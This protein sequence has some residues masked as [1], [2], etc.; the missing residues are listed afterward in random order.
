[1]KMKQGRQLI[2]LFIM[3][4]AASIILF[5]SQPNAVKIFC[6]AVYAFVILSVCFVLMLENRSP[7]KTL[8]WIY[9]LLLFPIAGY[10]F[11]IFSGQLEVNGYLFYKKREEDE[12]YI[13][14]QL[15]N[16]PSEYPDE[17]E[18]TP[19][20]ISAFIQRQ[21]GF[22]VSFHTTTTI[23]KNGQETFSQIK[24]SLLQAKNYI[25][26]EYYTFRPD[27]IGGEIIDILVAKAKEGIEVKLL[28]D[29]VGSL[30]MSAQAIRKMERA[31]IETGC[32]LPV[33]YGFFNQKLNFRNHRKIIV[34]DG[35]TGFA[36]GLNIGDEY[37][38]GGSAFPFWRDTHV[39][40]KGDSLRTL[41]TIFL[42]DWA[43]VNDRFEMPETHHYLQADS[44]GGGGTQIVATGPGTNQ[45]LMSDLYFNM[46]IS[47]QSS[48]WIATPYFAPSKAIRTALSV[49]SKKGIDIKLMVP[50]KN[51]GFLTEYAARSY[52]GELLQSGIDIYLYRKGFMHQKIMIVDGQS[53]SIGTANLDLR[54]LNLNFEVNVFLFQSESVETLINNYNED[55]GE[56]FKLDKASYE[57]RGL[58]TRA[59]E[60]FARLFSPVL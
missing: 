46:I 58:R 7:Y 8:L 31:G 22:P 50:D 48:V 34:I 23:L 36:G 20:N 56:S 30:Q 17:L 44:E 2:L 59:K 5:T 12:Q 24:E 28:Y 21:S 14:N 10:L 55:I 49:A 15:Q 40:I 33:K 25:H 54:S 41:H 52:F 16:R 6:L 26:M 18:E 53:A 38:D 39:M 57:N 35:E 27:Q 51:D 43:Y 60:S 45:G 37:L 1:M 9:V 13:Q 4:T 47:A 19:R 3:A 29:A 42:L 32:F 11:Y